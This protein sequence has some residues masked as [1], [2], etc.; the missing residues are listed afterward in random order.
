LA[1]E[2]D[3]IENKQ[4]GI[5]RNY[6]CGCPSKPDTIAQEIQGGLGHGGGRGHAEALYCIKYRERLTAGVV[7]QKDTELSALREALGLSPRQTEQLEADVRKQLTHQRHETIDAKTLE[8][9][10]QTVRLMRGS[11]GSLSDDMKMH[12]VGLGL[13]LG[14]PNNKVYDIID[15]SH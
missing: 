9:F 5:Y 6:S 12:L 4:K 3:G 7:S 8:A 10:R 1:E 15:T 2:R 13:Q 14:L 11:G